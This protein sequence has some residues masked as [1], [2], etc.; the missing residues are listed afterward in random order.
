[1]DR[2]LQNYSTTILGPRAEPQLRAATLQERTIGV[3]IA[4]A[5]PK[6]WRES[7]RQWL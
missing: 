4:L 6:G 7:T 3:G 5:G 2:K 1:M